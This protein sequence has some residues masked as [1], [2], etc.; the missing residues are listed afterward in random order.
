MVQVTAKVDTRLFD[1]AFKRYMGVTRRSITEVVNTKADFI[2]SRALKETKKASRGSIESSLG[3]YVTT[4]RQ[5]RTGRTIKSRK[6][7]LAY[8]ETKKQ[9]APLAALIINKRLRKQGFL[10]LKGAAMAAAI[11]R[12]LASRFRSIGFLGS[13]W[14]Q[15]CKLLSRVVNKSFSTSGAK[16]F[17]KPK[18][19][20]TP[21]RDTW[22][23]IASISNDIT[24]GEAKVNALIEAGAQ[25]ALNAEAASMEEYTRKKLAAIRF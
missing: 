15:A 14:I 5:T 6:L 2:A 22:T 18:G 12:M 20:A 3:R 16:A 17:G 11:R 23:P 10:G 19:G 4:E 25:R 9:P 7:S 24:K 21:A 8:V 13:G 1:E